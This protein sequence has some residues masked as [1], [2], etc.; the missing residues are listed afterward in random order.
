MDLYN[1]LLQSYVSLDESSIAI[2]GVRCMLLRFAAAVRPGI[3][4]SFIATLGQAA[5]SPSA[6]LGLHEAPRVV[7]R[8]LALPS[9]FKHQRGSYIALCFFSLS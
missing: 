5:H 3:K 2:T 1:A 8:S 7:Q 9:H 6:H 4:R